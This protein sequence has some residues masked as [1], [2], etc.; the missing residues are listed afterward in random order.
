MHKYTAAIIGA[1]GYSGLELARLLLNHPHVELTECYATSSFKLK[2]YLS[3]PKAQTVRCLAES[4][5]NLCN[6][7]YVFLATPAEVSLN[8]APQFVQKNIRVIDLSGAF[9]L[10]NS[11]YSRWYGFEHNQT[12]LL[13]KS[14][15]GLFPWI[16]P[17]GL[18][19][20]DKN[21]ALL[22][23]NP[24]CYASAVSLGLIPLLKDGLIKAENIVVDAK[25]GTSGGGRKAAENLL[26]TE[27]DGECLPYKVGRHQH[28][29]EIQEA[30]KM[31]SGVSIDPHFTTSLLPVRRGIIAG[32]YAHLTEG[33]SAVD[34]GR[35][36]IKYYGDQPL[37]EV[38]AV[39]EKPQLMSLKKVVGTAKTHIAFEIVGQKLFLFCSIDNLLKGAAGQAVENMNRL[40]DLNSN[41]GLTLLEATL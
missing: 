41:T 24:G 14:V 19:N 12:E 8:L 3:H 9:R 37:F 40:M 11:S 35:C 13:Q 27:V 7:D 26:F 2:D 17:S 29:P 21:Q 15:Y 33:T 38:A 4:E 18:Q 39:S 31:F 22:V 30:V 5:I 25:S 16:G 28:L 20:S 32:I 6:C 36:L 10:K 34:V 23:A 1:R